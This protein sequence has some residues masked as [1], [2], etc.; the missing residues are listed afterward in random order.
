MLSTSNLVAF[1]ATS[2]AARSR[3]FYERVLGLPLVADEPFALVEPLP[4]RIELGLPFGVF[5]R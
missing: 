5:V 3:A 4:F 1:V 2:D